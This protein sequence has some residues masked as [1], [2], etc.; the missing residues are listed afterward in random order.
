MNG[1]ANGI[2][3]ATNGHAVTPRRRTTQKAGP[4]FVSRI[5]SIVARLLTW[6]SIFTVLFRCPS[7]IDQ[8]TETSPRICK[9]YFQIKHAVSP[10]VEPY[11]DAYAA[12]YVELARPYYN[13]VDQKVLSPTWAYATKYGA[14]RVAQAQAFGQAQWEKSVQPQLAKYQAL[15]KAQYEQNLGPHVDQLSSAVGPY[16]DI[17]R[18]NALQTYHELLLPSYQFVEPYV[19][20]GYNVAS[21]FTTDTAL[22]SAAWAWN[23]TYLFLNGTV[24][25]QLRI[26]YV[27]NVEPQLVKIG[28]RLGRYSGSNGQKTIVESLSSTASKSASSFTKPSASTSSSLPASSDAIT[29]AT[30]VTSSEAAPP[31][32]GAPEQTPDST[33]SRVGG[34]PV[35]APEPGEG[36]ESDMRRTTREAVAEDLKAWQAKYAK[37]ADEGAAEIEERVDEIAKR[38]VQRHAKTMGKS[39]IDDLQQ[40]VVSELVTLRRDIRNIVGAVI[41]GSATPQE[42]QEQVTTVV[43]RAGSEV[44][45]KA[46]EVRTWRE[47]YEAELQ[48][49]ITK[50]AENHFKI[51]GSIRDLALQKIGMKWAWMDGITYKDWAK[52]HEL[53]GRFDEWEVDL[54]NLIVTHPSLLAAQ[55]E[56]QVIE[57]RGMELAQSAAQE[58]GRLKQVAGWKIAAKDDSDEFESEA[59]RLAAEAVESVEEAGETISS[60]VA[61]EAVSATEAASEAAETILPSEAAEAPA[62]IEESL[63]SSI[64][65]ASSSVA[66][67]SPVSSIESIASQA[68]SRLSSASDSAASMV[69]EASSSL[70]PDSSSQDGVPPNSEVSPTATDLAAEASTIVLDETPVVAGNTTEFTEAA[71]PGPAHMPVDEVAA[72]AD[73]EISSLSIPPASSATASVKS[74]FLGAAAQSVPSRKP[75]LD[76]DTFDSAN[77]IIESLRSDLPS[78]IAAAAS[79]AYAAAVSNAAEQYSQALSAVS[80]QISGTPKPAHEEMLSSLS[81]A[82][83]QAVETASAHLDGALKYASEGVFGTT[84]KEY[85]SIP[86]LVDWARVESIASERLNDGRSWAEQQYE[87]AKIAVGLATPTPTDFSGSVSSIASA[88]GESV[89]YATAAVGENAEKILENARHNYYAGLGVAHERYSQFLAAASSAFSSLTA[90]PTPTDFAGTASSIASVASE[91]A[92]SAASVAGENLAAAKDSASSVAAVVGDTVASAAAVGYDSAASAASVAGDTVSAAAAAGYDGA[93]AG[94]ESVVSAAGAAGDYV[95]G[96]WDSLLDQ[97][98]VQVYGAPTPTPWYESFYSAAGEYAAAA[99]SAFGDNAETVTSAAGT[100]ASAASDEASKQYDAVSSIVSE[101]LLGKEPTFS[102]SVYSRLSE[103]YSTALA[104]ASSVATA[105]SSSAASVADN[106]GNAASQATKAVKE[107]VDHLRDEL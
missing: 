45:G 1:I 75:I 29:S 9:P 76:D 13:T 55:A 86:T 93:A 69:K 57:D 66:D 31:S 106:V 92:S 12:P 79:S 4:G 89:A 35:V 14:P 62:S 74:A 67:A 68:A 40:S 22:P 99:T 71:G 34:E 37:A 102:E 85:P 36:E 50:A 90:T 100:Y 107:T 87:S 25:P 91:S 16:Y 11:Y 3:P 52:Y 78:T 27:E 17:A 39:V 43:R 10:H 61:E 26:V 94:Y 46:Q 97:L 24:W 47:N 6:Y 72:P 20:Q 65:E 15:A 98:S 64:S 77:S 88:A 49:A 54:K 48:A 82:Y 7:T 103:A 60:S 95:Q 96:S 84:T 59:T 18:T 28:Q 83:S 44:K 70:L 104:S 38:M 30:Q 81:S 33:R 19:H 8:C 5:F 42:A 101:V 58:L 53:R 105:A 32:S 41:K 73:S 2:K 21:A 56:G 80:V 23:K 51:L 63:V